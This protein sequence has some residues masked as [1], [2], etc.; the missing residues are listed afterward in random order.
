MLYAKRIDTP[1]GEM[2]A[3]SCDD[4]LCL[5]EF[6]NRGGREPELEK[7]CKKLNAELQEN[8]NSLLERVEQELKEYFKDGGFKFTV[9][10]KLIG[11]EFEKAVWQAVRRVPAGETRT[12]AQI[13]LI[14][15]K[16]DACRAVGRANGSNPLAILVPCHRLVGS[17]GGLHGYGSGLWRKEWLLKHERHEPLN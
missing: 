6:S 17:D 12:Y 8:T 11:T 16:P 10:L 13:A 7:L 9:P 15:G 4:E 2:I 3:V 14:I 5:L 1:L